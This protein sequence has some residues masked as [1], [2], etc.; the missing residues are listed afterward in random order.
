MTKSDTKDTMKFLIDKVINSIPENY[1][2]IYKGRFTWQEC[3]EF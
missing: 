3:N 1:C 2:F